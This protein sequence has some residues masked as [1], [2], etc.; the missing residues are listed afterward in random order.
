MLSAWNSWKNWH[1]NRRRRRCKKKQ[2]WTVTKKKWFSYYICACVCNLFRFRSIKVEFD[3]GL[4]LSAS[5]EEKI[6]NQQNL[7]GENCVFILNGCV[8]EREWDNV[9]MING[10]LKPTSFLFVLFLDTQGIW[11][12]FAS[13]NRIDWKLKIDFNRMICWAVSNNLQNNIN[14]VISTKTTKTTTNNIITI[15]NYNK[16]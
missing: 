3:Q 4:T 5:T 12:L 9:G 6:K 16:I 13:F 7:I 11:Y 2:F 10:F 15:N 1:A 8:R 14:R